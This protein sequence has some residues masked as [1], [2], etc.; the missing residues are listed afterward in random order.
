MLAKMKSMIDDSDLLYM[1]WDVSDVKNT[2]RE[3]EKRIKLFQFSKKS[4]PA[5]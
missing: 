3:R 4:A 2:Q 5:R 1:P